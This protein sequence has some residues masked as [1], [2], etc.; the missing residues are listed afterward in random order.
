LVG[1][2]VYVYPG[3]RIGQEGYGF[4]ATD[5]GFLTVP[6]LGRVVI[7]DDVEI[8]ANTTIDR[9]STRDT[10]IGAGSRLDNWCKLV[11]M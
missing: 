6:Q 4:A 7:G 9:G 8:G 11:T 3:A 1:A 10:I 2:R 5:A